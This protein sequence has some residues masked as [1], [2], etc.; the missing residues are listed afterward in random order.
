M[1]A[2]SAQF[3]EAMMLVG[4]LE[5]SL[6]LRLS[7]TLVWDY[8]TMEKLAQYVVE[9]DVVPQATGQTHVNGAKHTSPMK[10]SEAA[11]ALSRQDSEAL[12]QG[13]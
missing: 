11:P 13:P 5:D 9:K 8:P 10:S 12:R 2:L 7:P 6:G 4:D 3:P 1:N